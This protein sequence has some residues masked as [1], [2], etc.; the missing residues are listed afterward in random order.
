M[1]ERYGLHIEGKIGEG[2]RAKMIRKYIR[3]HRIKLYVV[4]D[5]EWWD[6]Y[7]KMKECVWR[8][9]G[10]VGLDEETVRKIL[11]TLEGK[12]KRRCLFWQKK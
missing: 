11:E 6:G 8:V 2:P 10:N 9:D 1:L 5:D 4:L 7:E 3:K 12:T